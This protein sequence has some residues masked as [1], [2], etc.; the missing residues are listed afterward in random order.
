MCEFII[1]EKGNK[2]IDHYLP[3]PLLV[4]EG[5]MTAIPSFALPGIMSGNFF[6]PLQGE[7]QRG[8]D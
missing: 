6:S 7:T 4:K 2:D 1:N 5:K 8:N 3:K